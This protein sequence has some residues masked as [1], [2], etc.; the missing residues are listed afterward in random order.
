MVPLKVSKMIAT[1]LSKQNPFNSVP[2]AIQQIH[3]NGDLERQAT[4]FFIIEERKET[5]LDFSQGNE[6]GF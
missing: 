4:M 2:K 6:K 1:D 3:F 5:V